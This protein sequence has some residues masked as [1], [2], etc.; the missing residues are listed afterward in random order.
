MYNEEFLLALSL[1]ISNLNKGLDITRAR[2]CDFEK[3]SEARC[4]S[5]AGGHTQRHTLSSELT[6]VFSE[7]GTERA[8]HLRAQLL[9]IQKERS[10]VSHVI[11]WLMHRIRIR[12]GGW[13]T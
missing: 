7:I 12:P 4:I 8:G 1:Q 2:L 6:S 10:H 5:A 9:G 3:T 13:L 11:T